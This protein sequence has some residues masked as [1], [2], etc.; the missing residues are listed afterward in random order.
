MERRSP[1]KREEAHESI[2]MRRGC[3]IQTRSS[4]TI[5]VM[6]GPN[7]NML[8]EREP[9]IYGSLSLETIHA[10]LAREAEALGGR[11]VFF[12][13]NHEGALIDRLQAAAGAG[14]HKADAVILNA[15]AYTHT[16]VALA[17]AVRAVR[18]PVIEV[19]L[20]NV[21]AREAFRHQ[22]YLSP[23]C[24]GVICGLG[25]KSYLCA[26]YAL[27]LPEDIGANLER[28]AP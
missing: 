7:L 22:S 24:A 13:S 2:A 20:S 19:H 15:G 23:V 8:G 12:Q 28:N 11:T 5:L 25:W 18:L 21:H 17:D 27:L 9:G 10:R 14:E 16:S 4:K 6:N 26:V 1:E 3:A